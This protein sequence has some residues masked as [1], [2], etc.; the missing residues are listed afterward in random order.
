MKKWL[1]LFLVFVLVLGGILQNKTFGRSLDD[2]K[3][4]IG[5]TVDVFV[6]I[7]S[8]S[9]DNYGFLLEKLKTRYNIKIVNEKDISSLP[10]PKSPMCF[11]TFGD[12]NLL[13]S[14]LEKSS[15]RFTIKDVQVNNDEIKALRKKEENNILLYHPGIKL[16]WGDDEQ[17]SQVLYGVKILSNGAIDEI[18]GY[19][20]LR[21]PDVESIINWIEK[22][23]NYSSQATDNESSKLTVQASAS[24]V[25]K[26]SRTNYAERYPYGRVT[27]SVGFY[28]LENEMDSAYDYWAIAYTNYSTIPGWYLYGS[29]Y[30]TYLGW[31]H[32]VPLSST[33]ALF[34][35]DPT[36]TVSNIS[37]SVSIGQS[38]SLAWTYSI[39]A[40]VVYDR[41]DPTPSVNQAFWDVEYANSR[42]QPACKATFANKPG[43]EFR[44]LQ[45]S[46]FNIELLFTGGFAYSH[47][48]GWD[49]TAHVAS[50]L[51][52]YSIGP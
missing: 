22:T 16:D 20:N 26:G 1:F 7:P 40:I 49:S 36:S 51:G 30:Q 48:Y 14:Q 42:D 15:V 11:I 13:R 44:I 3:G 39:P 4:I 17:Y 21:T 47:W 27:Y 6:V 12:K 32:N 19:S 33:E 45:G 5:K 35:W 41:S 31:I 38:P 43:S 9:T 23:S 24:W 29:G 25:L 34:D 37:Y 8:Y 10:L 28:K 2:S 46:S 52:N 18:E 50:A